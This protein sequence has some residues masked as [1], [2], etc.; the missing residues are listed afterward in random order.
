[1]CE[2]ERDTSRA[3]RREEEDT[4]CVRE[5]YSYFRERLMRV[6][7]AGRRERL[8]RRNGAH[9]ARSVNPRCFETAHAFL[10]NLLGISYVL[11]LL[12]HD[13]TFPHAVRL[14]LLQSPFTP[15]HDSMS[16]FITA[17]KKIQGRRNETI[18]CRHMCARP[19]TWC[20]NGQR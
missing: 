3:R 14:L 1:M 7:R 16:F 4:L 9:D 17:F 13:V 8:L 12:T 2:R 10:E 6:G 19:P 11:P 20:V 15:E 5:I 18:A